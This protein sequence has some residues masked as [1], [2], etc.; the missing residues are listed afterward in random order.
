MSH[1]KPSDLAATAASVTHA[2]HN[3]LAGM[4]EDALKMERERCARIAEEHMPATVGCS[5]SAPAI[6]ICEDIA[7][8]IRNPS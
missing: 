5:M 1:R 4:I 3:Y 7:A 6:Q 2:S 8:A